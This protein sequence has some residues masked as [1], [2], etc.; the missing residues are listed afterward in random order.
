MRASREYHAKKQ[1]DGTMKPLVTRRVIHQRKRA[2]LVQAF[3]TTPLPLTLLK[4]SFKEN[5]NT[6]RPFKIIVTIIERSSLH[7]SLFVFS[8]FKG[9]K[10]ITFA[11]PLLITK[12]GGGEDNFYKAGLYSSPA[13]TLKN[14]LTL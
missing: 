14:V 4:L 3:L 2:N 11:V 12:G 13:L 5:Y 9:D 6:T 10:S 8:T 1:R 7:A